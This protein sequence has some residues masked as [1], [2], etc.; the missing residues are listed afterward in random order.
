MAEQ[1][2]YVA[3]G[4]R[5]L[6]PFPV[7]EIQRDVQSGRWSASTLVCPRGG[8]SWKP[9]AGFPEL[10]SDAPPPPYMQR[11]LRQGDGLAKSLMKLGCALTL[12][13]GALF[14]LVLTVFVLFGQC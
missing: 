3:E 11:I 8:S 14:L 4:G 9:L 1:Q 6:G 10:D 13:P 12:L 7:S 2:W 5:T